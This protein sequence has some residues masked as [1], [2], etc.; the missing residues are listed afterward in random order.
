MNATIQ[1]LARSIRGQWQNGQAPDSRAALCDHPELEEDPSVELL[2]DLVQ[3]NV[4]LIAGRPPRRQRRRD[5]LRLS[6]RFAFL[7]LLS[8][9]LFGSSRLL[10]T[11][12]E[13]RPA[14][15]AA[16]RP[17]KV[18]AKAPPA[19]VPS[20]QALAS[21]TAPRPVDAAVFP[22]AVRKIVLDAGHGG[23]SVGT[24]TPQGVLEK[25]LTLDIAVRLKRLLDK[26]FQVVMTREGDREVS[27]GARPGGVAVRPDQHVPVGPGVGEPVVVPVRAR[28]PEQHV[29][30]GPQ[31]LVEPGRA[32][33]EVLLPR[34]V[35][36]VDADAGD[37]EPRH[38]GRVL[39]DQG[40][41]LIVTNQRHKTWVQAVRQC[42]FMAAKSNFILATSKQHQGLLRQ[43]DIAS[44]HITRANGDGLPTNF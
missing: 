29:P 3:Q 40:M 10:S 1:Q 41:D 32:Q 37:G 6:L 21:L 39:E 11:L 23:A 4:D 7:A 16:V 13:P 25:D 27:L 31:Q 20:T 12:A 14:V 35:R 34:R 15:A 33:V 42:G 9:A 2:R 17:A 8:L 18:V 26:E 19:A 36:V 5:T 24:R 38:D 44:F 30:A 28:R 22:L 43:S